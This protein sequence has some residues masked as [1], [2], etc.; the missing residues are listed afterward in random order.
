[1][2]YCNT[3]KNCKYDCCSKQDTIDG[4]KKCT[5]PDWRLYQEVIE[6]ED[7]KE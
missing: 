3:L 4:D 7:N 2:Q 1:M 6:D 5:F